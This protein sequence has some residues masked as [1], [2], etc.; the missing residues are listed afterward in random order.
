VKMVKQMS[1]K[2]ELAKLKREVP[3]MP[4]DVLIGFY[5]FYWEY[6]AKAWACKMRTTERKFSILL[7]VCWD[8]LVKRGCSDLM[9]A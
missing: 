1:F 8:E 6:K 9:V 3:F 4:D 2:E 5:K 7:N